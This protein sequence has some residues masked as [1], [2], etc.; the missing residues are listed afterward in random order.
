MVHYNHACADKVHRFPLHTL[1]GL[2]NSLCNG[3][4][5]PWA[6]KWDLKNCYW[7]V[8]LPASFVSCIWVAGGMDRYAIVKVPFGC[9]HV[10][11]LVQH[12][13]DRVLSSLPPTAVLVVQYLHDI[14][15]AG[16]HSES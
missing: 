8:Y 9:H 7:S 6:C 15:A 1:D 11:G 14:L 5:H 13:I 16:P 12:L 4:A 2:A 10:L 3:C